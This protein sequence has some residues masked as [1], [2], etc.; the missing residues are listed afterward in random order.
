MIRRIQDHL[1]VVFLVAMP[2]A[3]LLFFFLSQPTNPTIITTYDI[4]FRLGMFL[5]FAIAVTVIFIGKILLCKRSEGG[6]VALWLVTVTYATGCVAL[7][8]WGIIGLTLISAFHFALREESEGAILRGLGNAMVGGAMVGEVIAAIV[9]VVGF[10]TRTLGRHIHPLPFP[11]KEP[12]PPGD[13]GQTGRK[14]KDGGT[15]ARGERGPAG[16]PGP[17]GPPGPAQ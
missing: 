8:W 4:L 12:G 16:P 2:L 11:P 1:P 17:P 6:T 10:R 9:I 7:M 5:P 14:G 15:G 13:K 3:Y